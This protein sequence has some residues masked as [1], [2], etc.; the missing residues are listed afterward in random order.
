[1]THSDWDVV[2]LR[3]WGCICCLTC[4]IML[5]KTPEKSVEICRDGKKK[6]RKQNADGYFSLY[7]QPLCHS[8]VHAENCSAL[9]P[10]CVCSPTRSFLSSLFFLYCFPV[11]SHIK[12][13]SWKILHLSSFKNSKAGTAVLFNNLFLFYITSFYFIMSMLVVF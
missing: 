10:K 4:C 11:V 9:I 8:I 13:Y 2:K 5:A 3:F 1:M 6:K 12:N 7:N